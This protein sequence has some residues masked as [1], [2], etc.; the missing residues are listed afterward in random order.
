MPFPSW[1]A[2][3]LAVTDRMLDIAPYVTMTAHVDGAFTRVA[4]DPL[5]DVTAS[6]GSVAPTM[7]V[8]ER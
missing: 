5:L 6:G 2:G 8:E 3:A 7:L 1:E 4:T